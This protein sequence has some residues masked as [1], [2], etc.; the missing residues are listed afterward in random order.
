MGPA[1][2]CASLELISHGATWLRSI[3]YPSSERSRQK[4]LR[5]GLGEPKILSREVL[6]SG[7]QLSGQLLNC[8]MMSQ[9]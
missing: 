9:S 8:F 6:E 3:L 4:G 7:S 2:L 5:P 1:G